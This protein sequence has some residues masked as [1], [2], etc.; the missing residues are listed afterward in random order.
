MLEII[1]NLRPFI[2]DNYTRIHVRQY[3]R[4][5]KK[6]PPTASKILK[7]YQKEGLLES[8]TEYNRTRYFANKQNKTFTDLSRIHWSTKIEQSGLIEEIAKTMV[9]PIVILFGSMSKA[10]VHPESDID[11]AVFSPSKNKINIA[12]YERKLKRPIQIFTFKNREAVQNG[13][14]LNNILNGYKIEGK[15]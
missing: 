2:E 1:N 6:S 14:L 10:E 8:E 3:A 15:W 7:K 13:A 11:L 4:M 5:M 9:S 12:A